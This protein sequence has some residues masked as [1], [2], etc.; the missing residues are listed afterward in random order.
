[1]RVGKIRTLER[2]LRYAQL[3]VVL[4]VMSGQ[5][6]AERLPIK[7]YTTVDGLANNSINRIVRDSR[8]FLWFCTSDG[9]SRFDGYTFTNYGTDQG[10][11]HRDIADLLET[12]EGEYWIATDAGLVR[13]SPKAPPDGQVTNINQA[14]SRPLP[15]FSVVVPGDDRPYAKAITTLLEDREGTLWCGTYDGLYRLERAQGRFELRRIEIGMADQPEG[16]IVSDLL[17][18]RAG[19]LWVAAPSGL[20]HVSSEGK[21]ARYTKL[22]GLPDDYIHSLLQDHEGGLWA[23]TRY[24]G[25][26]QFA[27]DSNQPSLVIL[28]AYSTRDG[29]PNPWVFQLFETSGNKFWVATAHGLLEYFKDRD[30]QGHWLHSYTEKNGL[31]YYD[32]TAVNED[33]AGNLWLGTNSSGAMKLERNGFVT[34]DTRDGIYLISAIFGDPSGAVCFRGSVVGDAHTSVFEGARL[35]PQGRTPDYHYTRLGRFD[36]QHFTWFMPDK[37]TDLGWLNEGNTMETRNGEAWVGTVQALYRYAATD[38]FDQIRKAQPISVY[39]K[40]DGLGGNPPYRLY[41][42]AHG[43]LWISAWSDTPLLMWEHSTH[44]LRDLSRLP[45]RPEEGPHTFG[46][47]SAGNIWIGYTGKIGRYGGGSLTVFAASDGVPPGTIT[48]IYKDHAGRLWL[49]SARSGLIRIDDPAAKHPTF[50]SYTTAEGLSSNSTEVFASGLIVEDLQGHIYIGTGRGLDRLDPATGRFRHF[51]S[52]DGLAPGTIKACFRDREGGLWFGTTGGLSHLVP[53]EDEPPRAP[54]PILISGL[55]VSGAR[56]FV[57]ALGETDMFLPDLT[58]GQN[59]LQIDFIGLGFAPGEVLHYQYQLRGFDAEWSPP[60]EQRSVTYRLAPGRYKF[61][62]RALNSDGIASA[63]PAIITFRILP[64]LW[65]RWWSLS[66]MVAGLMLVLYSL[67]RYRVARLLELERIRTRIATDL[68]DDI[69]SSLSRMAILSEVA[70]RRLKGTE[71]ESVSILTDIAESARGVT[72]SMSDIVWAIDPRRDDVRNLVF[73]IRQFAA[74]LL[75]ARGIAWTL[76]APAEFDKIKLN[77][78]QRRHLFLIFKEAINNSARHAD[79]K[80]VWLNLSVIHSQIVAEVRDDGCGMPMSPN[81]DTGELQGHGLE[82][83]RMRAEEL[84]G[85][86]IIDSSPGGGTSVR[87]EVP[88]K[89]GIA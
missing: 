33:L 26:F 20:Y 38:S 58:S 15:M 68:H 67:Y 16:H 55:Q 25:F 9:L 2:V 11:P 57:G 13:F 29:M 19:S 65:A 31:N 85:N 70:K 34:Y 59:Q 89:R 24:G 3:L 87:V 32:I 48:S 61:M 53:P 74:D 22:D 60:S 10:L 51:T 36:G 37:I 63:S 14:G 41:E 4:L 7:A 5:G 40:E 54:P 8:G 18:D 83:I 35:D 1:M 6:K 86:L 42:D 77:P 72:D 88:L 50:V 43:N 73:R 47:D 69:G 45:G 76:Q 17:E 44:I 79:C 80:S 30:E 75:G 27:A 64:P 82:N 56:Q 71:Q 28:R 81:Q 23:G 62:A 12:R 84:G 78:Q 46:E 21:S 52:S 39:K 66:L 49:T